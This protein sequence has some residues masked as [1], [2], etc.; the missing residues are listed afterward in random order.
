[1]VRL[2]SYLFDA[3]DLH[4]PMM[5]EYAS[6]KMGQI[7]RA[8]RLPCSRLR[9]PFYAVMVVGMFPLSSVAI[10]ETPRGS[11]NFYVL[12]GAQSRVDTTIKITAKA[13]DGTTFEQEFSFGP[14]TMPDSARDTIRTALM[15]AGWVVA[16]SGAAGIVILG[17][18]ASPVTEVDGGNNANKDTHDFSMY[19]SEDAQ[20][21]VKRGEATVGEN[22]KFSFLPSA[23]G[24]TILTSDGT[25]VADIDG[26]PVDADVFAGQTP[27]QVALELYD[28]MIAESI[29]ASLSGS[30]ISFILDNLGEEV[31]STDL[32]LQAGGLESLI[33]IPERA[34]VPEPSSLVLLSVGLLGFLRIARAARPQKLIKREQSVLR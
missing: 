31:L 22:Y 27:D 19:V 34:V 26:T 13:K 15:S 29:P 5:P 1:M 17:H 6:G 30:D 24:S 12:S 2:F 32:T 8:L 3:R 4:S 10:A 16:N 21:G 7:K 25:M 28:A 33:S 20:S 23:P 18:G 14:G 9:R 11:Y